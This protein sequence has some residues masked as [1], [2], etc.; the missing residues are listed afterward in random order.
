MSTAYPH[1]GGHM[2]LAYRL[3]ISDRK[4]DPAGSIMPTVWVILEAQEKHG[5]LKIEYEDSHSG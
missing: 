2:R 1:E 4:Y 3:G 5:Y